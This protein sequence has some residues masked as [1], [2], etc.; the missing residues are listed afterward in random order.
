MAEIINLR[1]ARKARE[2][3][4]AKVKADANAAMHGRTKALKA[5]EKARAE[6]DSAKLDSHR[7]EGQD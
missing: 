6:K 4:A 2:K 7:R 5:R 1:T 3:A